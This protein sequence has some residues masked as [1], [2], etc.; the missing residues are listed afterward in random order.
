MNLIIIQNMCIKD[1]STILRIQGLRNSNFWTKKF[2]L[3]ED[4]GSPNLQNG[5]IVGFVN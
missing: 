5:T 4:Y 3:F 1:L 2:D